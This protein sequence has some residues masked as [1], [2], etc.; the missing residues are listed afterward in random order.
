MAKRQYIRDFAVTHRA[1]YL[2]MP[3][4]LV[5]CDDVA[6]LS[7]DVQAVSLNS[8]SKGIEGLARFKKLRRIRSPLREDWLSTFAKIPN[9]Q[10]A[11]FRLPK[12]PDIPSLA[13][14][15]NLRSLVLSCNRH[16]TDLEFLQGMDWLHSLC[17]SE[18]MGISSLNPLSTL[19]E[20]REIYIDGQISGKFTVDSISPIGALEQLQFAVLLFGVA[21]ANR[22][23]APLHNLQ[24]LTFLHLALNFSEEEYDSLL[25]ALPRLNEFS[26]NGGKRWTKTGMTDH[27]PIRW[28]GRD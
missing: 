21:K 19:T 20:L 9:L 23:L 1:P 12:S 8:K 16:Q 18:P 11:H 2:G 22:T 27:A 13:C 3:T 10:Y 5:P 24:R 15:T 6:D 7:P 4:G 28:A 14:L 25:K 17:V 26:F